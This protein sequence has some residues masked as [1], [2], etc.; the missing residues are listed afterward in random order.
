MP[1]GRAALGWAQTSLQADRASGKRLGC[2]L[3]RENG[4]SPAT[5]G[6]PVMPPLAPPVARDITLPQESPSC[7]R[8]L[9]FG[10][11]LRSTTAG[12]RPQRPGCLAQPSPATKSGQTKS[13]GK[14]PRF[15]V[16][17]HP[18]GVRKV[19]KWRKGAATTQQGLRISVQLLWKKLSS[20][21][22]FL[23]SP[24]PLPLLKYF[25]HSEK[26]FFPFAMG[27]SPR[28]LE[29]AGGGYA[30]LK[31][32]LLAALPQGLPERTPEASPPGV[33]HLF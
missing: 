23:F 13:S 19:L 30:K 21:F 4:L 8:G 20:F 12:H 5:W 31:G 3:G 6:T 32:V 17:R 14:H 22:S 2:G 29:A 15:R 16:R 18:R 28:Q 9:P 1:T 26:K 24:R 11:S 33:P 10:C 27:S 7:P 25:S